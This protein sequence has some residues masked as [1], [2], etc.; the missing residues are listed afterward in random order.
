MMV[1]WLQLLQ[2]PVG[3]NLSAD[4]LASQ[5][6]MDIV[7]IRVDA[8]QENGLVHKKNLQLQRIPEVSDRALA[9]GDRIT[10]ANGQEERD[11]IMVQLKAPIV[12]MHIRRPPQRAALGWERYEEMGDWD[13]TPYGSE[14]MSLQPGDLINV[15]PERED[16]WT[17][18]RL[19]NDDSRERYFP[20]SHTRAC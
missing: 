20:P 12:H 15:Q 7:S 10:S 4:A 17:F 6:N 3:N 14:D 1:Y 19:A 16:G 13:S 8:V 18:G 5:S 11:A 9:S 2:S